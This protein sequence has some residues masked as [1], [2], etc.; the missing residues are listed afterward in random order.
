MQGSCDSL[1]PS[2]LPSSLMARNVE[3]KARLSDYEGT[4]RRAESLSDSPVEIIKQEDVFFTCPS[5]RLKLRILGPAQ[6]ELIFYQRPDLEGPK[7]S[8]YFIAPTSDPAQMRDV[9][10]TAYGEQATVKKVRALYLAGRARIHI[11]QVEA[12]GSFLEI[13][14]VLDVEE[15]FKGGEAEAHSLMRQLGVSVSQLVPGAYVDLLGSR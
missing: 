14:V 12:L 5:G 4:V 9:L 7:T 15:S 1:S 6:G 11:D 8:H 10:A 2:P 3:I 13:E